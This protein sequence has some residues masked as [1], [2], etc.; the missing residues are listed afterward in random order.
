MQAMKLQALLTIQAMKLPALPTPPPQ[1]QMILISMASVYLLSLPL[2]FVYFLHITLLRLK[3]KNPSMKNKTNHQNDVMCFRKI[4]N[5]MS[6]RDRQKNNKKNI[7]D[8]RSTVDATAA[9]NL[10]E[11]GCS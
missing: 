11:M 7:D 3:V 10:L 9:K 5:K 8:D 6:K 1:D 4:C 2:A